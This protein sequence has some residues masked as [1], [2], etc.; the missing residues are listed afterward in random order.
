[1][2]DEEMTLIGELMGQVK[3]PTVSREGI[4]KAGLRVVKGEDM[5][6]LGKEGIV[7]ESCVERCLVSALNLDGA[8]DRSVWAIMR[9]E[10]IVE[11]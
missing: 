3:P 8:D 11:S 9:K 2:T 7:L 4:E 5:L 10:K 1:M 6:L